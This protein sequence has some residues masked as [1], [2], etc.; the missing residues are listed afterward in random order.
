MN[1][2]IYIYIHTYIHI[3][4][5]YM[6]ILVIYYYTWNI[7]MFYWR[8]YYVSCHEKTQYSTSMLT[9]NR[10]PTKT[11]CIASYFFPILKLNFTLLF[12]IHVLLLF[13][14]PTAT[15]TVAYP[16]FFSRVGGGCLTNSVEDRGQTERGSGGG[17]PLVRGSGGSCNLVQEI[18]FHTVKFS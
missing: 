6:G 4:R 2:Y 13:A 10:V 12:I 17:N 14:L 7:L 3:C 8:I 11:Y 9:S 1:I 18:S 5:N 15:W 16:E